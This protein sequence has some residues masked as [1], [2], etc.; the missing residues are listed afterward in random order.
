MILEQGRTYYH[1]GIYCPIQIKWTDKTLHRWSLLW[2]TPLRFGCNFDALSSWLL[3]QSL[4]VTMG[5]QLAPCI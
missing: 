4:S 2:Y 1:L 3:S 5:R